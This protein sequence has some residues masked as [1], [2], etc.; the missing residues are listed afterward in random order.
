MRFICRSASSIFLTLAVAC[1]TAALGKDKPAAGKVKDAVAIEKTVLV[2]DAGAAFEPVESFTPSDTFGV[3]VYL[4]EAKTGT[5]VKAIWKL[6][7]AGGMK[8]RNLYE[9]EAVLTPALLQTAKEPNRLDFSLK[10]SEPAPAG[11][12]KTEIYVNDV[13]AKTVEFKVGILTY[14]LDFCGSKKTQKPTE[15]DLRQ[16]VTDL[17]ASKNDAFLVLSS[18]DTTYLQASGD[19]KTGFVL[20]HQEGDLKHHYKASRSD[21]TADDIVKALISYGTGTEEWKKTAEWVLME[22]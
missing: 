14:T 21:L 5:R 10:H 19:P 3:L 15:A 11:S 7:D 22:L 9:K 16:A 2:R 17:D 6:V 20:E 4:N 8:D 18:S 13:L 12:F 1:G